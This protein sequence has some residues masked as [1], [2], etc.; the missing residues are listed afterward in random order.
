VGVNV[1]VGWGLQVL[2]TV[3][4]LYGYFFSVSEPLIDW[5]AYVPSWISAWLP[6]WQSEL[7]MVAATIGLI[8]LYWPERKK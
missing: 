2:G 7:G 5:A 8:P 3:L 6:N 1:V 4:W